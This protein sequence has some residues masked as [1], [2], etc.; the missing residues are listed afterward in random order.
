MRSYWSDPHPR[1]PV[2]PIVVVLSTLAFFA[3]LG[4][5]VTRGVISIAERIGRKP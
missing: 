1:D 4:Y 3:V 2:I 5:E